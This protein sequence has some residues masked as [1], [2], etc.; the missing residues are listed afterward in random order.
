MTPMLDFAVSFCFLLLLFGCRYLPFHLI[1]GP[2]Q[3][4]DQF[5]ALYPELDEKATASSQGMCGVCECKGIGT[6]PRGR[7]GGMW[8]ATSEGGD[9]TWGQVYHLLKQSPACISATAHCVSTCMGSSFAQ[10]RM[11]A[12][13]HLHRPSVGQCWPWQLHWTGP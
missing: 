6:Q 7:Q 13:S 1:H 3:V 11:C 12:H 2:N 9:V 5:L 8:D 4:P 10:V